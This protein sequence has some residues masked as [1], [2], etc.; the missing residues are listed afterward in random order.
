M[1]ALARLK[2]ALE[3]KDFGEIDTAL[4]RVQTQLPAGTIREAISEIAEFILTAEFE[5]AIN[6]VKAL[7]ERDKASNHFAKIERK[8]NAMIR[9]LTACT[10]EV[11]D[12]KIATAEILKQLDLGE[13]LLR[14]SV[15]ILSFHPD[16]LETGVVKAISEALP[17]DSIG[18]MASNVATFGAMGSLGEPMLIVSVLT[19]DDVMFRAGIS[20]A[21]EDAPQAPVQEL[22][23]RLAPPS[24][25]K[26]ALLFML[27]TIGDKVGGDDFVEVL[28]AAS[29]GTP[30]FGALASGHHQPDIVSA[31]TCWN[32]E[33]H[34]DALVLIAMFGEVNPEF[35]MSF[36]PEENILR[37]RSIITQAEKNQI[38]EINGLVPVKYLESIGLVG[39]NISAVD[40]A[41]FPAV[42]TLSDG[43]RV[44]RSIHKTTEEGYLLSLGMIPQGARIGFSDIDGK[45]VRQSARETAARIA[46][47][48]GDRSAL[49]FSCNGRQWA[50]GARMNMEIEELAGRLDDSL[51]YHF[52]YSVGEICPV[53]NRDG[54]WVNRFHNFSIIACLL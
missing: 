53:R 13:R 38:Q 11:D 41:S 50:L 32:G 3:A 45:F 49:I 29:G 25:G 5:K 51:A 36:I 4:A 6:A 23:S 48:A 1:E 15:G 28:D 19:S 16:F 26:P 18:G 35:F 34:T 20:G 22:Y 39:N 33:G 47:A 37:Q 9:I 17:F 8:E 30:V 42:L 12:I 24:A 2:E 46:A 14:N 40:L 44:V 21:I 27:A 54:Q 31:A 10:R 7:L 43:S 52:A